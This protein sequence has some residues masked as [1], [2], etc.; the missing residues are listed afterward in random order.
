MVDDR[1]IKD[2]FGK[3]IFDMTTEELVEYDLVHTWVQAID[4]YVE[5]Q[6]EE[7]D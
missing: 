2:I 6:E 4:E 7:E 5:S 3:S 1:R